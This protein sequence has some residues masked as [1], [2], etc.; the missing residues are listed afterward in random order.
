MTSQPD[1]NE[2]RAWLRLSL[3]P[4]VGPA[5]A[6]S[7][8]AGLGL[9]QDVFSQTAATL[10]RHVPQEVAHRLSQPPTAQVETATNHATQW[11]SQPNRHLLTLADTGYPAPLLE[12]ADPPIVLYAHGRPELLQQPALGMVGARS[13]TAGGVANAKAFAQHLAEAGWTIASGLALGIDAAAHEGALLA[14]EQGGSTIAVCG[15]GIDQV[16]PARHRDLAHRIAR[17]G[18]LISEFPLGTR[19]QPWQFAKRNRLIAGLSRGVLVVEA[20]RQSGSLITARLATE[21][22]REVFAIPG[23]IHSPLSRGCHALIRQGARLVESAHDIHD[24]LRQPGLPALASIARPAKRPPDD[25]N[26]QN[27]LAALG[28]DTLHP[29]ALLQRTGLDVSTIKAALLDLE[30]RELIHRLPDG[31]YQQQ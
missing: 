15:T 5:R 22:G 10:R 26:A 17:H 24:E 23:S 21:L 29:D 19:A 14:G 4:D 25:A 27:V 9:P 20:A 8:L 1:L 2:T 31:S 28:H 6:R 3:E 16:Y 11:L 30:L 12:T 18:L 13:A 7:L